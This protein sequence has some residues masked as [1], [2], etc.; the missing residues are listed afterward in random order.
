MRELKFRVLYKGAFIYFTL[1]G[2]D[3]FSRAGA[4]ESLDLKNAMQFTGLPEKNNKDIY[5]GD[6]VRKL[7]DFGG[8]KK[9]NYLI[10]FDKYKFKLSGNNSYRGIGGIRNN[11]REYEIIGNFYENPE[12]LENK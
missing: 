9:G 7:S 11:P 2:I 6:I 5:E 1:E 4:V 10:V 3:L 8:V 12:L